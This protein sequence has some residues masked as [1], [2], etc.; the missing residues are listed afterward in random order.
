MSKGLNDLRSQLGEFIK[1]Y[2]VY[3]GTGR[4]TDVYTAPV[5]LA[6]GLSCSH[7]QYAYLSP[8]SSLVTYMKEGLS[9]WNSAWE[10]F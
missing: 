6:N 2:I 10:A 4:P 1:Q 3:D 5:D 9:T 7:V 8:T